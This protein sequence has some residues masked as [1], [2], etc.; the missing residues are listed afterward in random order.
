MTVVIAKPIEPEKSEKELE[1]E[2][3]AKEKLE[4]VSFLKLFTYATPFDYLLMFLGS[5]GAVIVGFAMPAFAFIFGKMV[6]DFNVSMDEL[7]HK[8]VNTSLYFLYVGIA[9]WVASYAQRAC[10]MTTAERQT[11]KI[12]EDFLRAILRQEIAWF[13]FTGT[14]ALTSRVA[15]DTI[16]ISEGIGEKIGTL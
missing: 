15:S 3:K 8:I 4:R 11:R 1:K 9:A 14:G 13:D 12:R 7:Y 10:W 5:L 6:D 2:K 16:I